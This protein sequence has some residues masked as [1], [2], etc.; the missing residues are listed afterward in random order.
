M[1]LVMPRDGGMVLHLARGRGGVAGRVPAARAGAGCGDDCGRPGNYRAQQWRLRSLNLRDPHKEA[2][3]QLAEA[4]LKGK[5][6]VVQKPPPASLFA[7]YRREKL[8]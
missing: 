3:Q 1:A 7:T 2:L 5:M 4:T 6:V 8:T